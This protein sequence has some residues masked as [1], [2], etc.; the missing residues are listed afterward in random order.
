MKNFRSVDVWKKSHELVL[1][2]YK[3]SAGFPSNELY[4][5]TPWNMG[6][7]RY[8]TGQASQARRAASSIP[9][10]IARPVEYGLC[11]TYMY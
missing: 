8:S 3:V 2:V 9:E 7:R 10:N 1:A 6:D 4:G 5:P 11:T